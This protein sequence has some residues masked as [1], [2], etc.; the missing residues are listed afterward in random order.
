MQ[1][2]HVAVDKK[3]RSSIS[4]WYSSSLYLRGVQCF[5]N[6][7]ALEAL[8]AKTQTRR[9][10]APAISRNS[11]LNGMERQTSDEALPR[12]LIQPYAPIHGRTQEASPNLNPRL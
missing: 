6:S 3:I 10:P 9:E 2:F 8:H 11:L 4:D 1:D 5:Q 12:V 7:S